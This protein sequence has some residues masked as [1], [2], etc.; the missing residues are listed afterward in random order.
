MIKLWSVDGLIMFHGLVGGLIGMFEFFPA[1][2]VINEL[3][4]LKQML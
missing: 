1:M 4:G 3:M 2:N